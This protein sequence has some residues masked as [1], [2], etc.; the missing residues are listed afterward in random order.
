MSINAITDNYDIDLPDTEI[1]E[2]DLI[3]ERKAA[4]FSRTKEY[5]ELKQHLEQR[6]MFYQTFLPDGSPI[7][8]NA[9]MA[10]LGMKWAVANAIIAEFTAVLT[11]YENARD[12][13]KNAR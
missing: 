11:A 5:Q 12:V 10:E 4:K 1:P 8:S 7:A 13:V 2:Q 3:E 6:I 9:D